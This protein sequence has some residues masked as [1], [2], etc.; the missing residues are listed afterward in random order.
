M[1]TLTFTFHPD[2]TPK[3]RSQV[4]IAANWWRTWKAFS[5]N[6]V[7]WG[8]NSKAIQV[9]FGPTT[10]G[11]EA[12]AWKLGWQGHTRN[13][14]IIK[15]KSN[16]LRVAIK[17]AHEFGH[18]ILSRYGHTK[19][20]LMSKSATGWILTKTNIWRLLELYGQV[21]LRQDNPAGAYKP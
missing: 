12:E 13:A 15:P 3:Q 9:E 4:L 19:Y 21:R 7:A 11:N 2:V 6:E 16:D 8:T 5:F 1:K 18:I 17:A 20:G 14:I 10:Y